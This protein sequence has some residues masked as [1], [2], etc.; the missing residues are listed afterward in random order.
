VAS[1][2]I[3]HN[4]AGVDVTGGGRG[5]LVENNNIHDQDAVINNTPSP[6]DDD[7]G[8][9]GLAA[10]SVTDKPG[11]T[12]RGNT[13]VRNQG[14]SSDYGTDGGGF[15]LYAASNTTVTGNRF[16][17]ND[18]VVET[19]TNSGGT[20]SG[21]VFSH[22][23]A[24]GRS[25]PSSRV[26]DPTGLIL[27]CAA[28]MS[29]TDNTLTDLDRFAFIVETGTSFAGGLDG[30]TITGNRVTQDN[31]GQVFYTSFA[32]P[33]PGLVIDDNRYRT[34]HGQFATVRG[35]TPMT[36]GDWRART[37]YDKGSGTF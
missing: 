15:E 2:E 5:V 14:P 20:C 34:A 24:V 21:N 18:D 27:R 35:G 11:P 36:F 1:S 4:G 29:V 32:T 19:G 7:F 12:F 31:G 8:A 13:V 22:N 28:H 30:L 6:K 16:A 9:Y 37:G 10:T 17:D 26:T 23:T 3:F 25:G 33:Q